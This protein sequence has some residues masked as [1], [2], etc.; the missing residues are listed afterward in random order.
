MGIRDDIIATPILQIP[1]SFTGV[2]D[3]VIAA[4]TVGYK[5]AV[6]QFFFVVS[7]AVTLVFKSGASSLIS[8]PMPFLASGAYFQ[9]FIELP[10]SCADGDAFVVNTSTTVT[11]GGT[12]WYARAPSVR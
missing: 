9:D 7:A 8:G 12:L 2:G 3:Q 5:I 11:L 6:L 1:I 4:G 10:M